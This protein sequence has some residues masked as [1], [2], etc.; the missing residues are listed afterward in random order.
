MTAKSRL[1]GCTFNTFSQKHPLSGR[2][3]INTLLWWFFEKF[4]AFETE[5]P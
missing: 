2:F 4:L 1:V 5:E 3:P